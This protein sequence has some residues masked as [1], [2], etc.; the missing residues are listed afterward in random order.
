MTRLSPRW[1]PLTREFQEYISDPELSL[2]EKKATLAQLLGE[3]DELL[4]GYMFNKKQLV[5]EDCSR[6]VLDFFTRANNELAN[7]TPTENSPSVV[8]QIYS[9]AVLGDGGC[10][11]VENA[12]DTLD[13]LKETRVKIRESSNYIRQKSKE[14]EDLHVQQIETEVSEKRLTD[15]GFI[16]GGNK[17][18][19]L[20]E[21]EEVSIGEKYVPSSKVISEN[22]NLSK[23]FTAIKDQGEK[24]ACSAF[25]LVAILEY[26]LKKNS[27]SEPDLSEEFVYYNVLKRKGDVGKDR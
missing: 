7:C 26:I 23:N 13:F 5:L 25:A 9:S 21:T 22:I 27:K 10:G 18:K 17:Y 12:S 4:Q 11:A 24:G 20:S 3:D 19:L 16:F 8:G 2:P 15:E 1:H 6:E 14:L